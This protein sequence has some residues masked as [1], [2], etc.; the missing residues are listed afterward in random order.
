MAIK[1]VLVGSGKMG[2]NHLRVV[3][4]DPRFELV[5]V[6]DPKPPADLAAKHP[7]LRILANL[8]EARGFDWDCAIVAAPTQYHF[9]L[10]RQLVALRKPF[11]LEKPLASTPEQCRELLAEATQAGVRFGVGH[12]ERFNPVVRKVKEVIAS[13]WVGDPLHFSFTRVGGYPD[14]VT[15]G[16]NVLLD[17]AVHDLDVLNFV[18]G[19]VTIR[20][21]V[22]HSSWQKG[23]YDTAEILAVSEKGFSANFHVNWITPTKIRTL[24]VTGTR[25][26]CLV[27]YILQSC[28]LLGG[29]LMK[30]GPTQDFDFHSLAEEYRATDRVEFGVKKEEPLKVQ[31]GELYHFLRGEP[32]EICTAEAGAQAVSLAST[33][34]EISTRS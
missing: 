3:K 17:L 6:V 18:M 32:S 10:G 9:E 1:I 5:A 25:G 11:L 22:C 23:I 33:A 7:G 14:S 4:E 30:R 2:R 20:S 15:A 16:N 27:D 29:N 19:P 8:T 21:S 34:I 28:V 24:R 26:V 13:G 31:L 12:V